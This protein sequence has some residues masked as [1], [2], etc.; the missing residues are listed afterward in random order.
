MSRPIAIFSYPSISSLIWNARTIRKVVSLLLFRH[1]SQRHPLFLDKM[2]IF[3]AKV[4]CAQDVQVRT[5]SQFQQSPYSADFLASSHQNLSATDNFPRW[6]RKS[7][8][9][10]ED[11]SIR[12]FRRVS[13]ER[14]ITEFV[15]KNALQSEFADCDAFLS[16][17]IDF[18]SF[19]VST[20]IHQLDKP[21]FIIRILSCALLPITLYIRMLNECRSIHFS[22]SK[23]QPKQYDLLIYEIGYSHE[24]MISGPDKGTYKSVHR[25]N[26]STLL[27]VKDKA[28]TC[29]F[30]SDIWR[31]SQSLINDY[32][33]TLINYGYNYSDWADFKLS[34]W[35]ICS[36]HLL[37][38]KAWIFGVR[39]ISTPSEVF[40]AARAFGLF[41]RE[42]IIYDNVKVRAT[43]GFDDYSERTIVRKHVAELNE[44]KTLCVQHSA[45][46]GIRSGPEL[47]TVAAHHYLTLSPFA[48]DAFKDYWPQANIVLFGYPRLDLFYLDLKSRDSS[49]NPFNALSNPGR[50]IVF[51]TLPNIQSH[52]D[53]LTTLPGAEEWVKFLMIAV[54]RYKD[55]L[56]I[57]L[58]PKYMVGWEETIKKVGFPIENV[59]TDQ[60]RVTSEYLIFTD[61]AICSV[62]SGVMSECGLLGV[63]F[64]VF[65]LVKSPTDMY[66]HLGRGFFNS[67]AE[68]MVGQIDL[69]AEGKPLEIDHIKAQNLFS[70]PFNPDRA[71]LILNLVHA[72]YDG[73]ATSS[74]STIDPIKKT[75]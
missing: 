9:L 48:R 21:K 65:D 32:K 42:S 6:L 58:R 54:D 47:A 64:A 1:S 36:L 74:D 55:T 13:L 57:Y 60:N 8:A 11:S 52:E 59:V 34:P 73:N 38:I 45:N 27:Y 12:Y 67:T 75:I 41:A 50:P 37:W 68:D 4:L 28:K 33:E 62:G 46:D 7:L 18:A 31:P 2:F 17:R 20:R 35:R 44:S 40:N 26:N 72:Q 53:F 29:Q 14:G 23:I 70:D 63:D 19:K 16:E 22:L 24:S 51:F 5:I 61:L 10:E 3:L 66:D 15:I 49:H 25:K 39:Y 71:Q 56:N 30:L 43:L 69:L